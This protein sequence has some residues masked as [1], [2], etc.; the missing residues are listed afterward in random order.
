MSTNNYYD[1]LEIPKNATLEQIR[2]AYRRKAKQYHPDVSGQSNAHMHFLILRQAYETLMDANKRH[3][4]DMAM[5]SNS[6]HLLTYAQWKEIERRKIEALEEEAY[7]AFMKRKEHFQQSTFF[8]PAK[9]LLYV[10][11]FFFYVLGISILL[12]CLWLM[13]TYHLILFFIFL[14]FICLAIFL[15]LATPKWLK[16][17]KRYF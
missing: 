10:A 17:A 11:P 16:E 6:E 15:L 4:Y 12:V 8:K 14:P 2:K 3:L 5:I 1:L 13:W 9:A 7:Q